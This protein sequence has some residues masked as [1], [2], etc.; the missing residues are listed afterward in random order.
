MLVGISGMYKMDYK[1][2]TQSKTEVYGP[3]FN[4]FSKFKSFKFI[5]SE[6]LLFSNTRINT[7]MEMDTIKLHLRLIQSY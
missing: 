5:Q 3:E 7:Y 6:E 2:V 4:L 1:C